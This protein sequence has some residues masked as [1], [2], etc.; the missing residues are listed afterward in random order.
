MS[1]LP[2]PEPAREEALDIQHD[3]DPA[4]DHGPARR[5]PHLGHALLFFSLCASCIFFFQII[6][7]SAAHLNTPE[8]IKQHAGLA[9]LG[10]LLGYILT[11]VIAVPLFPRIWGYSF[12][13]GIHWTSRQARL[14][15]WKLLLTGCALSL[16]AELAD[17]FL[18]TPTDSDIIELLRTPLVAWLTAILG[19]IIAPIVEEVA[20]RGFLLPALATAYDWCSLERKPSALLQWQQTTNHTPGALVFGAV[21]SSI[22]FMLLHGM[23]LHW[24]YGPLGVLFFMSMAFA[25]IRIRFRSV[26][27]ST[28]VHIAYDAFL[29]AQLIVSTGGFRHL[30]SLSK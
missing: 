12:L 10:E 18:K 28:L 24:A 20:F 25:G 13:E 8:Q 30:E 4:Q 14:H 9:A 1:D 21:I 7:I 22:G 6:L 29:F 3:T 17:R 5:I 15:W 11:F 2:L 27:A 26:A 23:Q 16:L 19:S